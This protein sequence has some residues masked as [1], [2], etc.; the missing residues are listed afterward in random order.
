MR[1]NARGRQG[2]VNE[3]ADLEDLI[4]SVCLLRQ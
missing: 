4:G 3:I 1:K 2:W